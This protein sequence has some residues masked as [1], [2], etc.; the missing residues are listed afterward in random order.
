MGSPQSGAI[1]Q[2]EKRG[3]LEVWGTGDDLSQTMNIEQAKREGSGKPE[4]GRK[5]S[6]I[7]EKTRKGRESTVPT[8]GD[9]KEAALFDLIRPLQTYKVSAPG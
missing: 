1:F 3:D 5:S 4:R 2:R 7:T 8:M 9:A 6:V